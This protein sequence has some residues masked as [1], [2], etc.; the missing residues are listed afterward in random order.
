MQLSIQ[1]GLKN[2]G[3]FT[4]IPGGAPCTA[5]QPTCT[6]RCETQ[7]PGCPSLETQRP[8]VSQAQQPRLKA[9]LA[10][11]RCPRACS[12]ADRPQP[13]AVGRQWHRQADRRL[14]TLASD[15]GSHSL[16]GF[17]LELP[18]GGKRDM[19]RDLGDVPQSTRQQTLASSREPVPGVV[20]LR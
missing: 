12:A 4:G 18:E 17:L 9:R 20:V 3:E 2:L 6:T 1:W 19:R 14:F 13:P 11:W 5:A 8:S 15:K 10:C 7:A 16:V